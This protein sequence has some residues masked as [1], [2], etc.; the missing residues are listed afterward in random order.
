MATF[1]SYI[2]GAWNAFRNRDRPFADFNSGRSYGSRP[3]RA[4]LTR[5]A[6]RSIVTAVYNRIAI[7]VAAVP[8]IHAVTDQ[9]GRYTETVNSGIQRVLSE[10]ANIDQTGRAFIQDLVM[11]MLDEGSVAAVPIDVDRNPDTNDVFDIYT[12][13]VGKIVEWFPDKV[14]VNVYDDRV[15]HGEK[16]D[17]LV[18]KTSVAIIENPLYAVMNEN[19]SSMQRLIHKLALLDNVD[20]EAS[21]GKLDMIIQLPYIIKTESRRKQAEQR[22]KDIESQLENSRYGVAYIDGT[23]KVTQLNKSLEN[24]LL[25]QVEYLTEQLYAQ[26]GMTPEVLNGTATEEAMLNYYNRTIEPILAAIADEFRRKFIPFDFRQRHHT[27]MYIRNPFR[28]T[29]V[30]NIAEIADKFTRNEVLTS[31]EVRGLIGFKPS[32]DPEADVLRNKNLNQQEGQGPGA[33][34]LTSAEPTAEIPDVGDPPMQ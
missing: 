12:M 14:R 33:Q 15:D 31:N 20:R 1:M 16:R 7:D 3:D 24:Q 4:V 23:E 22:R 27:I 32:D 6:G 10:E 11:S 18:P 34:P 25:K 8:I 19:Q 29:P 28:L 21:S 26:L 5:G 17:I 9:N 30:G 2:R 13:R